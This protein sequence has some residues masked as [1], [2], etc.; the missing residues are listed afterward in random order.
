MRAAADMRP[1]HQSPPSDAL[2]HTSRSRSAGGLALT[3]LAIALWTAPHTSSWSPSY[4]RSRANVLAVDGSR[5]LVDRSARLRVIFALP[6]A[7][8]ALSHAAAPRIA[9][10]HWCLECG[11]HSVFRR[12]SPLHAYAFLGL[13]PPRG[14]RGHRLAVLYRDREQPSRKSLGAA[15]WV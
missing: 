4:V 3:G 12:F 15:R 5:C 2:Q 8:L 11:R 10:R 13:G 6:V 1:S 7:V 9:R 14:R